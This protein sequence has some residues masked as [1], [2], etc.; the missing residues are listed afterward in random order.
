MFLKKSFVDLDTINKTHLRQKQQEFYIHP[1]FRPV[2]LNV[3][4][5]MEMVTK[6]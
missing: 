3:R 6:F 5:A 4:K 2:A 1:Q